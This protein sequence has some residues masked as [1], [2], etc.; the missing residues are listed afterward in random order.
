MLF[1]VSKLLPTELKWYETLC[2]PTRDSKRYLR[3]FKNICND[4]T[5]REREL[6][7]NK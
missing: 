6:F 2:Q 4:D 3:F 1:D 5:K 7:T